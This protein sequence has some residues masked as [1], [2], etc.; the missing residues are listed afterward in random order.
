MIILLEHTGARFTVYILVLK[1]KI[2]K[3][4]KTLL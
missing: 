3:R 4:K 2:K 1:K